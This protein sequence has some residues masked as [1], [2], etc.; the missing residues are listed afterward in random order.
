[1]DI[2]KEF[3]DYLPRWSEEKHQ[4][5]PTKKHMDRWYKAWNDF[6]QE[7]LKDK[8]DEMCDMYR[9]IQLKHKGQYI[10]AQPIQQEEPVVEGVKQEEP[11]TEW[12]R[13]QKY[14]ND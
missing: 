3:E 4:P 8:Y 2:L 10:E 1:M 13:V 7:V 12:D 6:V 5:I 11:Q 9:H 14:L